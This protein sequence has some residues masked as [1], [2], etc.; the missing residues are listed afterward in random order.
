MG[1]AFVLLKAFA[2]LSG[3]FLAFA[4]VKIYGLAESVA[5]AIVIFAVLVFYGF[6]SF[7]AIWLL[8]LIASAVRNYGGP[9]PAEF[10]EKMIPAIKRLDAAKKRIGQQAEQIIKAA[11]KQESS[12]FKGCDT[13]EKLEKRYKA[14]C[15]TYHPDSGIG[16]EDTLSA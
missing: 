11:Q 13:K 8:S 16:D 12:F 4:V 1:K 10:F 5:V 3:L 7:I 6:Y 14:L 9:M 2:L 15:K